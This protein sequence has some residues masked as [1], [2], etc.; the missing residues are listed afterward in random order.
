[1]SPRGFAGL[2]GAAG[3]AGEERAA[4]ASVRV[5]PVIAT[6]LWQQARARERRRERDC[7]YISKNIPISTSLLRINDL[8]NTALYLSFFFFFL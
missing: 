5:I 3:A 4:T 2:S 6:L 1:M 7:I 8:S